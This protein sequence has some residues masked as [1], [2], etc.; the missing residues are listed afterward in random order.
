MRRREA[1]GMWKS[2][3]WRSDRCPLKRPEPLHVGQLVSDAALQLTR[4]DCQLLLSRPNNAK[5]ARILIPWAF[6]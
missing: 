3:G 4:H 2:L 6:A 1:F 5:V